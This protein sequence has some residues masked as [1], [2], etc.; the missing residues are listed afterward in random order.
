MI[1]RLL[2]LLCF[3]GFINAS[4]QVTPADSMILVNLYNAYRWPK[5]DQAR[6]LADWGLLAP[7]RELP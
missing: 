7:G 3:F 4:A 2:T 1:T 6:E 5:L